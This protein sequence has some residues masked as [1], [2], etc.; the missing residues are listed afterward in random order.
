MESSAFA[1]GLRLPAL[2]V[3][4]AVSCVADD[5]TWQAL[6][7]LEDDVLFH[8]RLMAVLELLPGLILEGDLRDAVTDL[9]LNGVDLDG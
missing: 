4:G 9:V 1:G 3:L 2:D 7:G 8:E 6:C 5:R